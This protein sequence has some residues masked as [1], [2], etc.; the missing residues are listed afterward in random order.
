MN[1]ENGI[2]LIGLVLLFVGSFILTFVL[3]MN[4]FFIINELNYNTKQIVVFSS[5]I[6]MNFFILLSYSCLAGFIYDRFHNHSE[7]YSFIALYF[8]VFLLITTVI[9]AP[10]FMYIFSWYFYHDYLELLRKLILRLLIPLVSSGILIY[11]GSRII[12]K[13]N[14]E[15]W[16]KQK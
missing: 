5:N 6:I 9:A 7:D 11:I 8:L 14:T 10:I 3:I 2:I 15:V 1:K 4:A 12:K 13:H 16:W